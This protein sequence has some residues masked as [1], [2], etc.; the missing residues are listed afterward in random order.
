MIITTTP[1]VAAC[2]PLSPRLDD[3]P[4]DWRRYKEAEA[5]MRAALA[6]TDYAAFDRAWTEF[7]RVRNLYGG[8]PPPCPN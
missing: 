3:P 1:A 6:I 2:K 4:S 5:R 7:E 8:M